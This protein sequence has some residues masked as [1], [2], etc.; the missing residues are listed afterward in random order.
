MDREYILLKDLNNE[1]KNHILIILIIG[2][3]LFIFIFGYLIT[4]NR[5]SPNFNIKNLTPSITHPFGTDWLGRDMF[6][7]TFKGLSFSLFIGALASIFSAFLATLIG[8]SAI[9]GNRWINSIVDFLIDLF[10][11][12]PHLVL[13]ILLSFAFGKGFN[14]LLI[15]IS[16]T[17]WTSLAR[18]IRA[19]ILQISTEEYIT[20]SKRLG[21]SYIWILLNHIVPH[22]LPQFITGI[23]L[24]FPHAIL[25][26]SS[27]SFLG[28]GLP[29]EQPT[30][31]IILAESLKH[32]A[33]GQWWISLFPGLMLVLI[34]I[35]IDKLGD[36]IKYLF[37][38]HSVQRWE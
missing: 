10:M 11:G 24:T 35:L 13:M 19:E 2:I 14:G 16:L 32:I 27:I 23:V 30:I 37:K 6:L 22:I 34:V 9:F 8:F 26:E 21:R 31:G 1:R 18:L 38:S 5:I 33:S 36:N 4:N 29:P 3:L 15:S 25:H 12:I 20:I 28:Y 17:H 7:R